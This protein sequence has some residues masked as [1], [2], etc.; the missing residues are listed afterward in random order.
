MNFIDMRSRLKKI[1]TSKNAASLSILLPMALSLS[2]S[3]AVG[4]TLSPATNPGVKD[5]TAK[6][7][8]DKSGNSLIRD[9]PPFSGDILWGKIISLVKLHGG[10]IKPEDLESTLDV[11][12][13][14][15]ADYGKNGYSA[16]LSG[17]SD[18]FRTIGYGEYFDRYVLNGHVINSGGMLS[19]LNISWPFYPA[20]AKYC[21]S[22]S[23]A[24]DDLASIGWTPR[25]EDKSDPAMADFST[26]NYFEFINKDN[27][28]QITLSYGDGKNVIDRINPSNACIT[29]ISIN[30]RPG[31]GAKS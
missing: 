14:H 13:A 30:G 1:A 28:S 15:R 31:G 9:N 7:I 11:K 27:N 22:A 5:A 29:H 10:F 6:N 2:P 3:P 21:M 16:I 25:A 26:S 4:H 12:V 8:V 17:S 19:M 20:D 23:V 18:W 24:R